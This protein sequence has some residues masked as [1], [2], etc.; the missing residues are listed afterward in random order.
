M[1]FLPVGKLLSYLSLFN[2]IYLWSTSYMLAT[3][4]SPRY[5]MVKKP[6][7]ISAFMEIKIQ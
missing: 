2:N 5:I 1:Y 6:D 7:I 4:Q 3:G